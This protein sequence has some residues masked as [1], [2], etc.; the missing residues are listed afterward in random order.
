MNGIVP[1]SRCSARGRVDG[2]YATNAETIRQ[3]F[4]SRRHSLARSWWVFVADDCRPAALLTGR[5]VFSSNVAG[6]M[7]PAHI[8][9]APQRR[10]IKRVEESWPHGLTGRLKE[11]CWLL[12]HHAGRGLCAGA[13]LRAVSDGKDEPKARQKHTVAPLYRLRCCTL[14][15]IGEL[16]P[17]TA[18]PI[19]AQKTHHASV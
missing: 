8:A 17:S 2:Y 5:G 4:P 10:I 12:L 3:S 9:C 1:Y 19:A 14:L 6:R 13:L 16:R 7:A 18:Y 15:E 11:F